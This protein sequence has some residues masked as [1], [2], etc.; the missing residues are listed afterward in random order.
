MKYLLLL[1]FAASIA[2]IAIFA[3]FDSTGNIVSSYKENQSRNIQLSSA[4]YKNIKDILKGYYSTKDFHIKS[5]VDEHYVWSDYAIKSTS[6]LYIEYVSN[7]AKKTV[8]VDRCEYANYI[9]AK[10]KV[11]L[12]HCPWLYGLSST[13]DAVNATYGKMNY[14]KSFHFINNY[15]MYL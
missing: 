6:T 8:D 2:L 15:L 3:S 13:D 12:N 4:F 9:I 5:R 1:V 10:R 7:G 11:P 14:K